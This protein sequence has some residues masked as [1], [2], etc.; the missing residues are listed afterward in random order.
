MLHLLIA[1]IRKNTAVT[2]MLASSILS[3]IVCSSR[4][5]VSSQILWIGGYATVLVVNESKRKFAHK[6]V[7]RWFTNCNLCGALTDKKYSN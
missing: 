1:V 7:T 6:E 3:W 2:R 5:D 4:P